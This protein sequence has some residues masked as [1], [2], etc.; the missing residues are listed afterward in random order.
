MMEPETRQKHIAKHRTR[1]ESCENSGLSVSEWIELNG[2]DRNAY[3]RS[4]KALAKL[5]N[6][7]LNDTSTAEPKDL[8]AP[9]ELPIRPRITVRCGDIE[10]AFYEP[11]KVE[12]VLSL[13]SR[14]RG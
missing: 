8:S 11:V 7:A 13:I 6:E 2:L 12:E 1:V 9:A 10:I 4:K 5:N 3:Y 14:I